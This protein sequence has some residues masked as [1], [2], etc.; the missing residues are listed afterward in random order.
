MVRNIPGGLGVCMLAK[1]G[2][3]RP[4]GENGPDCDRGQTLGNLEGCGQTNKG[5][6]PPGKHGH[7]I[8][9]FSRALGDW[10]GALCLSL[11]THSGGSSCS[12]EEVTH[13]P[14][15]QLQ[16]LIWE[17]TEMLTSDLCSA[18][19]FSVLTVSRCYLWVSSNVGLGHL[20]K[21]M[22]WEH[23]LPRGFVGRSW[24]G[25]C[26]TMPNFWSN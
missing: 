17:S 7:P 13:Q 9:K 4:R 22:I 18:Q 16:Q 24:E 11:P 25:H 20:P 1:A 23:L 3:N 2:S 12:L 8:S 5:D 21:C 6:R 10:S 15:S 26:I 14:P 19:S